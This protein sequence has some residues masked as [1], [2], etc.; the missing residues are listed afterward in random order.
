VDDIGLGARP[1]DVLELGERRHGELEYVQVL[2][3][4]GRTL[5]V[6]PPLLRPY[7]A[8]SRVTRRAQA[9]GGTDFLRWLAGWLALDLR[10]DRGERWNRELVE[11]AGPIWPRRGT[12]A[13]IEAFLNGYLRG[14]AAATVFD[15][16]QPLQIGLVSTVGVDTVVGGG[17]PHF[18]WVDL[19][20]NVREARLYSVEGLVDLI[21]AAQHAV[22]SEKPA[23]T[24]YDLVV[25]AHTMQIGT[26]PHAEIGARVGDTTILWDDP[27]V[28]P[29]PR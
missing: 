25:H 2:G 6:V 18:F 20:T 3:V 22:E 1:G 28:V 11:R 9:G 4:A 23:H 16:A 14:D 26:D 10:P 27:L 13:G 17:L 15:P 7:E 12:R 24:Y 8:G 29:G 5:T 21:Q 19:F